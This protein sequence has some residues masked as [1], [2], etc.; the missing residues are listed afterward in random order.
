M[1]DVEAL[2]AADPKGLAVNVKWIEEK[3]DGLCESIG[4]KPAEGKNRDI[5]ARSVGKPLYFSSADLGGKMPV[6]S[7]PADNALNMPMVPT[8]PGTVAVGVPMQATIVTVDVKIGEAVKKGQ[9]L[10]VLNAMKMEH[11]ISATVPGVV[12]A[13]TASVGQTLPKSF[14]FAFIEPAKGSDA[15]LEVVKKVVDL[16]AIRPDLAD[17]IYR[18]DLT[19]DKMR[20]DAV[21]RRRKTHHRTTRE[22]ID[23]LLDKGSFI[24]VGQHESETKNPRNPVS[25][26][27]CSHSMDRSWLP[28]NVPVRALRSS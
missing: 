19:L 28:L 22:N 18:H 5:L 20:P 7:G 15:A 1:A 4:W 13:I 8:P 26:F 17:S 16:D 25:R 10:G 11:V 23:D 2:G 14:P 6:S 27:V 12:R 21:A 3:M 9:Q 24:E